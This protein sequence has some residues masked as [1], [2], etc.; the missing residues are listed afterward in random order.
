V[1]EHEWMEAWITASES[2]EWVIEQY[3][4]IA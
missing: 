4:T 1:W 2:E 3:E